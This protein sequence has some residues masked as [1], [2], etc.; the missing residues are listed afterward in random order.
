MKL[1]VLCLS[2]FLVS[3]SIFAQSSEKQAKYDK[4]E[5]KMAFLNDTIKKLEFLKKNNNLNEKQK[6]DLKFYQDS[7]DVLENQIQKLFAEMVKEAV[8]GIPSEN[9]K[10]IYK[11]TEDLYARKISVDEYWRR[12]ERLLFDI[13]NRQSAYNYAYDFFEN[14]NIE[15]SNKIEG[16]DSEMKKIKENLS[17]FVYNKTGL[18]NV[19]IKKNPNDPYAFS[20]GVNKIYYE[21]TGKYLPES[22]KK[23]IQ[24]MYDTGAKI[25]ANRASKKENAKNQY[26]YNQD[27]LKEL[28]SLCPE[29]K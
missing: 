18:K 7:R 29:C 10:Q 25:Y 19:K 20:N 11:L 24:E 3:H 14:K 17:S 21:E 8:G 2:L 15:I 27:V 28:R 26:S 1:I 5:Q 22:T 23:E 4:L 6:A 13:S 16:Y 12:I 9:E